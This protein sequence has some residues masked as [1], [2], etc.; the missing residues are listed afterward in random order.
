MLI[1]KSRGKIVLVF[2]KQR[3]VLSI[4]I[5]HAR[6]PRNQTIPC[7][8]MIDTIRPFFTLCFFMPNKSYMIYLQLYKVLRRQ[9]EVEIGGIIER[10]TLC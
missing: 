9:E 3:Y 7:I 1:K 2:E 6:E 8:Y 5:F 4:R 10:G